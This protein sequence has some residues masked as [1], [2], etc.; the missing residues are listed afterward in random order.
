MRKLF[1]FHRGGLA[2]SLE[3]MIEVQNFADIEAAV[4]KGNE[5]CGMP[6]L[7]YNLR[8]AECGDDSWRLGDEWKTTYYVVADVRGESTAVVGMSNFPK[9]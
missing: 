7:F 6:G 4:E 1:R 9:E 2:E 8:T 5:E 3:T